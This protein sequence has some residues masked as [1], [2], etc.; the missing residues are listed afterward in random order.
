MPDGRAVSWD[1]KLDSDHDLIKDWNEVVEEAKKIGFTW[2]GDWASFKDLPHLE[3]QFGLTNAQYRAGKRPSQASMDVILAKINPPK[4][5]P[6]KSPV[7]I[8]GEDE[9]N[10]AMKLEDWAWPMIQ[11]YL[12][13]AAKKGYVDQS[14]LKKVDSKSLTAAELAF[15]NT[16]I[17]QRSGAV[18]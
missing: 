7:T 17:A 11:S 5:D 2:G 3:I 18:K 15:L 1:T 12:A 13:D 16:I 8:L 4:V 6:P 10:V 9:E 14:W